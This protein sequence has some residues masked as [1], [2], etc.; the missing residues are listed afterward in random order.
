MYQAI[1]TFAVSTPGGEPV[2]AIVAFAIAGWWVYFKMDRDDKK[3]EIKMKQLDNEEK[4]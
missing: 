3:H 4:K 2:L 1:S